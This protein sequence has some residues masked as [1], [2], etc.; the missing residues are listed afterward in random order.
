MSARHRFVLLVV[1]G[2]RV[3]DVQAQGI[4]I[5]PRLLVSICGTLVVSRK[6]ISSVRTSIVSVVVSA[7]AIGATLAAMMEMMAGIANGETIS[8]SLGGRM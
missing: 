7:V 5:S 2:T 8:Y 1:K 6:A 3:S 4:I